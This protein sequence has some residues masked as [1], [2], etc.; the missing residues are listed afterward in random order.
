[1]THLSVN[2]DHIATLREARKAVEPDPV[3]A[4]MLAE[5]AGAQGVT[6]HLR[7][8]RRHIQERDVRLI[9]EIC[10]TQMDLELA[11]T[12]EM[13]R[14]ACEVRPDLVTLVPERT[15]E[16]TTQG[17]LD[18]AVE[19]ELLKET[20]SNLQEAGIMVSLFVDPSMEA[21]KQGHRLGANAMEI[22]T[23]RYAEVRD[24]QSRQI[25][26]DKVAGCCKL[27][28]KLGLRVLA[29]HGL[30]YQNVGPIAGIPEVEELN[31]GHSIIARASLVGMERAV[32]EMLD[33]LQ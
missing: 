7:G 33:L 8:D 11:A 5:M 20:I 31:I 32:G 10:K 2:V 17:G 1:M 29:G 19:A 13:V 12:P 26:L 25:E 24:E 3:Q 21:I 6:I 23:G 14:L 22:N 16:V 27:L 15:D 4:A 18:M 28:A 30:D 9:R